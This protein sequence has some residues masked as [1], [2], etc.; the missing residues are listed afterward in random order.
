MKTKLIRLLF[1]LIAVI[2]LAGCWESA[3]VIFHEPGEYHG[4]EDNL[5]TN[6]EELQQRFANQRDR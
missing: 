1:P 4:A 2:A 3:D 6:P 5:T